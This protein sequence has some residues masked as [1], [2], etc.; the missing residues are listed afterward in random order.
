MNEVKRGFKRKTIEKTIRGKLESWIKTLPIEMQDKV[1][2]DYIV[3]GGAIASMLMGDLPNDYDIYFKTPAVACDVA[4]FYIKQLADNDKVHNIKAVVENDRV[5]VMIRS[6]GIAMGEDDDFS[7]YDYFESLDPKKAEEYFDKYARN[8][9]NSKGYKPAMITSN[10]IS[11]HGNIQLI[12]RFTGEP[13]AIHAN[14]DFVHCT[15]YYT[16]D[17]GLVLQPAALESILAKELKYVGSLYPICSMFRI[18]K[19][20]ERGWTITA[21]EMLKISWDINKLN[22]EDMNVLQEQLIGV[23]AAYFRQLL[24]LLRAR[25]NI[26]RTYLIEAVN[27][28]FDT[29][30][31]E[32]DIKDYHTGDE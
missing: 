25:E 31:F 14:Y 13:N 19:F 29:D 9:K 16:Y 27:R 18:K 15:N 28:V 11:L 4:N 30:E 21:G 8:K 3:T 26:D 5:R 6:V 7:G 12:L 2:S 17:G 22:L 10:A 32:S 1:R 23:D 24:Y 20:I